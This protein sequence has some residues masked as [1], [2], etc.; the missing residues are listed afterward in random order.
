MGSADTHA[1]ILGALHMI[2]S[3]M[4]TRVTISILLL[5]SNAEG[6]T[7]KERHMLADSKDFKIE[8]T[9]LHRNLLL[10]D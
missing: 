2:R 4:D 8:L 7:V 9:A 1:D 3:S 6:P 10:Y 5:K